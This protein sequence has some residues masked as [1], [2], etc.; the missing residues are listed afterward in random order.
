[1]I[2]LFKR[3]QGSLRHT[4][5]KKEKFR[6]RKV[7][8]Q[9]NTSDLRF[10]SPWEKLFLNFFLYH[11]DD[12]NQDPSSNFH[13]SSRSISFLFESPFIG[14]IVYYRG[15]L[16]LSI[17]IFNRRWSCNIPKTIF[18]KEE[19]W[20]LEPNVQTPLSIHPIRSSRDHSL[21]SSRSL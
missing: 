6:Q 4:N 9:N 11:P 5:Q 3:K 10:A 14:L 2:V 17:I 15:D 21:R 19:K 16:C 20:K 12:L 7:E 18:R 13:D 8:K 1:V